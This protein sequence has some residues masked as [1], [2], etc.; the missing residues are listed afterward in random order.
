MIL[1]DTAPKSRLDERLG[2][3]AL[4]GLGIA[5]DVF[6]STRRAFE[7]QLHLNASFP[8]TIVRE[9]KLLYAR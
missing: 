5:K 4:R 2:Y 1:P 8:S 7:S 6:V 9:G 3:R